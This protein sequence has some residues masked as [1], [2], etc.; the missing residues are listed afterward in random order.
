MIV[1]LLDA[2]AFNGDRNCY[3]F[4][5]QKCGL[6]TIKKILR[7]EEYPYETLELN[8][9]DAIRD[10]L[11]F[12]RFVLASGARKKIGLPIMLKYSDWDMARIV[13]S[14]CLTMWLVEMQ[15]PRT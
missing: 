7:G 15:T 8:G 2:K 5:S 14:S 3:P 9:G 1:G 6:E 10:P 4:A 13:P 12:V 11:G